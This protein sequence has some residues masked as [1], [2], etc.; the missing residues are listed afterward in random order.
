MHKNHNIVARICEEFR[1]LTAFTGLK[2]SDEEF[3]KRLKEEGIYEWWIK[4][5]TIEQ[6]EK[7]L[8]RI[9]GE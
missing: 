2:F 1:D 8:K 9:L 7:K 5:K 3:Y 4:E 6:R